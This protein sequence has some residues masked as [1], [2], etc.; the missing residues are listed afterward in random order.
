M[1]SLTNQSN[2]HTAL[3]GSTQGAV[4]GCGGKAAMN[5]GKGCGIVSYTA[6][7]GGKRSRKRRKTRGRRKRK[8][9]K[10]RASKRRRRRGGAT[11]N[12]LA[13]KAGMS[14]MLRRGGNASRGISKAEAMTLHGGGYGYNSAVAKGSFGEHSLGQGYHGH[15]T[16][17]TSRYHSCG[18]VPKFKMGAGMNYVGTKTIQKGAG[19]AKYPSNQSIPIPGTSGQNQSTN[20][21]Y[22]YTTGKNAAIFAP[23]HAQVTNLSHGQQCNLSGGGIVHDAFSKVFSLPGKVSRGVDNAMGNV[24]LDAGISAAGGG[25]RTRRRK[26]GSMAKKC[27]T[28]IRRKGI[29][30]SKK[31][32]GKGKG[33]R[34]RRKKQR[35]GYAQ[36]M[37]N[38]PLTWTQQ[39]PAGGAGGTWE[40]QLA[41]PPTY[42]RT[43]NC[44]NNY[45]HFTGKNTPSP[46]LDQAVVSRT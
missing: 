34:S 43:N 6:M 23:G 18:I 42:T 25:R 17:P 33:R 14:N 12:L 20:A 4:T 22:G 9:V 35:G 21:S 26:G 24:S 8:R 1:P 38:V 7:R 37:S 10:R 11:K 13:P 31:K 36:Y 44:H 30:N 16:L 32:R 2:S 5:G 40:G 15:S 41:S 46:V 45:N 19:P 29:A 39:T 28:W 3:F 27:G